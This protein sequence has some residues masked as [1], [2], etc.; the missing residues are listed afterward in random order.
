MG[1]DGALV[2][3]ALALQAA[4]LDDGPIER[5][6]CSDWREQ[7]TTCWRR[8]AALLAQ[9]HQN[10][11]TSFDGPGYASAMGP[12]SRLSWSVRAVIFLVLMLALG[13]VFDFSAPFW[14]GAGAGA[15]I[16]DHSVAT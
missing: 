13:L 5:R 7:K 15:W 11:G 1:V 3:P 8:P 6:R 10:C 16:G 12:L 14:I 9:E 2:A 4:V